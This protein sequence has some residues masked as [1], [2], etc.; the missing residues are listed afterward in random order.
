MKILETLC[1]LTEETYSSR[2]L[3]VP[4]NSTKKVYILH[5]IACQPSPN[6]FSER[7]LHRHHNF[8]AAVY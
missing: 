6:Y 7:S 2:S 3:T 8:S 1:V 5:A 4:A